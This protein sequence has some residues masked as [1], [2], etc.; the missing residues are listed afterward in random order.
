MVIFVS[1]GLVGGKVVLED[2]HGKDA[3]DD[4]DERNG[5][6]LVE[7]SEVMKSEGV[8]MIRYASRDASRIE[9]RGSKYLF[10]SRHISLHV[11]TAPQRLLRK[12]QR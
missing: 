4:S 5:P 10:R 2:V 7:F 3:I 8:T 6:L 11:Q 9:R 1:A 12:K